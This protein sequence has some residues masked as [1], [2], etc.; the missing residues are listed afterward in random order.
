MIRWMAIGW[1]AGALAAQAQTA[2]WETVLSG[3]E[4]PLTLKLK[5]LDGNWRRFT[6]SVGV[7]SA[8]PAAVY[9]AMYGAG[10]GPAVFYTK[11]QTVVVAG[12]TYLVAY[13]IAP[14]M[15]DAAQLTALMRGGGPPPEPEKPTALSSL[16][17]VLLHLRSVGS[18]LDVRPFDL[19][20]ELGGETDETAGDPGGEASL[21]HLRQLGVALLSYAGER[22]V[23]PVLK[24]AETAREEL[25]LYLRNKEAFAHPVTQ[26]P[27]LPNPSLSGKKLTDIDKPERTVVFYEPSAAGDNTRGVLYLDGRAERIAETQWK[28]LK[29]ASGIP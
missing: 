1:M 6:A 5:D 10:P 23:L 2:T 13:R 25:V 14:K 28:K 15:L 17:L 3:R 7:E 26:K 20:V 9:R 19:E 8:A 22:R 11:G 29:E 18:V 12:E 21:K 4:F 16:R 27:Y 24:D